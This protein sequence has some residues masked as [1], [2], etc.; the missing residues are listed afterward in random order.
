M[1]ASWHWM[2]QELTLRAELGFGH[3]CGGSILIAMLACEIADCGS[4]R[5]A[6]D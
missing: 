6:L 5:D 1:Q 2:R 4:A 3:L